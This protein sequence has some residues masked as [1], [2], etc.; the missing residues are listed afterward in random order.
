MSAK[1]SSGSGGADAPLVWFATE[2]V[3]EM[4]AEAARTFPLETGGVLM[5]YTDTSG[6]QIVVR[7]CTGPGTLAVHGGS[8]FVPDH[9]FH[10]RE[11]ARI[12]AASGRIWSYLGDWHSHPD[13]RLFLSSDD[14]KTLGRIARSVNARVPTPIM[15]VIAG[16]PARREGEV[17]NIEASSRS[18]KLRLPGWHSATWR[19]SRA[20]SRWSGILSRAPIT[21]CSLA[22]LQTS[23]PCV[24]LI[25]RRS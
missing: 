23:A 19:L 15:T 24:R 20:P 18:D 7:A 10:E 16:R 8:N 2:V 1:G 4:A 6:E 21:R 17:D 3:V 25:A 13:G 11:V 9:E 12:Y 14:R 5:G 22:V